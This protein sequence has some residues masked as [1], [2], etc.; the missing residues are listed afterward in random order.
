SGL[1]SLR[2]L[3]TAM[4]FGLLEAKKPVVLLPGP[5]PGLGKGFLAVNLPALVAHS[6]KAVLLIDPGMGRGSLGRHFG[7]GGRRGLSELLSDQVALEEAIRETSAPGLSSIPSG[8]RPPNPSELLMSLRLSQ[9]LD[10]PGKR[11]DTV[12]V[13][14]PPALAVP[15]RTS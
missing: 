11:Y 15:A 12:S 9:H 13:D 14:S 4:Q 8:A 3:R 2:S 7:T 5:N 1:Q 6:G 10:G